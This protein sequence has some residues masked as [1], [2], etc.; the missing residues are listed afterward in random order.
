M[1]KPD[2]GKESKVVKEAEVI[3]GWG[4]VQYSYASIGDHVMIRCCI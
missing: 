1:E 4:E 2:V 3:L